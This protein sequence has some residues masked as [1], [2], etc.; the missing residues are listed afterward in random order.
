MRQV[1]EVKRHK[2]KRQIAMKES[3][4][5]KETLN[6][7]ANDRCDD[8][9]L[10]VDEDVNEDVDV[11]VDVDA[12]VD[13]DDEGE[14]ED[15]DEVEYK[16]KYENDNEHENEN[17]NMNVYINEYDINSVN[18][19]DVGAHL[20]VSSSRQV[21]AI[22]ASIDCHDNTD[23]SKYTDHKHNRTNQSCI[24]DDVTNQEL[25]NDATFDRIVVTSKSKH[26]VKSDDSHDL[27]ADFTSPASLFMTSKGFRLYATQKSGVPILNSGSIS[28]MNPFVV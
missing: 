2:L 6:V 17:E 4:P 14:N 25:D 8:S 23:S 1:N 20:T 24:T 15:E 10:R 27:L 13:V 19:K 21:R 28:N 3:T 9:N 26:S 16:D 7:N 22:N 5:A 18:R 11:D 12:I